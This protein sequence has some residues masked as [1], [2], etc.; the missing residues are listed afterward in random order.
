MERNKQAKRGKQRVGFV[1]RTKTDQFQEFQK[2]RGGGL[3]GGIVLQKIVQK[4]QRATL[5]K[6]NKG[7]YGCFRGEVTSWERMFVKRVKSE[8]MTILLLRN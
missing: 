8:E 7:S 6:N 5:E 4:R 3:R 1:H 2:E